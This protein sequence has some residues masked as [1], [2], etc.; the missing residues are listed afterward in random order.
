[1]NES[2]IDIDRIVREVLAELGA[3]PSIAVGSGGQRE[4][5]SCGTDLPSPSIALAS[6]VPKSSAESRDPGDLV[7]NARVVTMN[8]VADRLTSVRR[9]VVSC[10]AIVTP[11]VRDE[12]LRRGI[13]LECADSQEDRGAPSVRLAVIVSGT[14]FD[15]TGLIASLAREGLRGESTSVDCLI[16]AT[17][18]LAAEADEPNTLGVLLTT[19]VAAGLCLANRL[20]GVRAVSGADASGVAT[21]TAAVAANVLVA[22]PRVGTFFQLKQMVTEFGRCGVRPCPRVFQER[23]A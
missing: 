9:L 21:A 8:E 22:D 20:R 18:Q 6:D 5:A 17:D 16:A 10:G 4:K 23:L 14:D 15:P 1:M 12:L 7:V 3:A 19:H 2:L 11:A 13:V